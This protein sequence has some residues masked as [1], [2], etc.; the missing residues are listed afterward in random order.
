MTK[1]CVLI[2]G[3]CLGLTVG[4]AD[5]VSVSKAVVGKLLYFDT[6]LSSP[7]GQSC[8]SCH[9]PEAGFADPDQDLPVSVGVRA[10]RTG[11]RNSP[12]AAYAAYSPDFHF[13]SAQG[14]YVGGQFWDGREDDLVG[15]AKGP[16]LNPLEMGNT[17]E[18]QV[19]DKVRASEYADLFATVFGED[20]F[21]DAE[22]AYEAVGQAI[23]AYERSPEVN[24]FSSKFDAYVKGEV[25]LSAQELRGLKLFNDAKR[26]KC[27]ECHVSEPQGGVP[28]LF[29]D[30]TYDNLGTPKNPQNP[31][32]K[33]SQEHN[34]DGEAFVDK[35]L[36][37]ALGDPAY[38]GMFKVPTLRNIALTAPYMHNGV[39]S[40]LEQ[41]VSFYNTR[42]TDSSWG[43]PEV[44]RNVNT[45]ELGDLGLTPTEVADIVAFLQT[46]SDGYVVP[47]R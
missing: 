38:D 20:V 2:V 44:K 27:A 8:A 30:F 33:L 25:Q 26:A 13:D 46:L 23:A 28:A 15:Q 7:A 12:S 11:N 1:G 32:Y 10:W 18:E 19:V 39:F 45:E 43:A 24:R 21:D 35:G 17:T 36:G 34:P 47:G 40:T 16:F 41:V 9:S 4:C 5:E 22:E 14:L 37:G 42:D 29:T 3:T 6:N 31:F